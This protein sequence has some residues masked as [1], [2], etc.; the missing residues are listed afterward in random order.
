MGQD[1]QVRDGRDYVADGRKYAE[2]VVSGQIPA[3]QWVRLACQRHLD[4]LKRKDWKYHF[5][6]PSAQ[7]VCQF[8]E[9]M[10]HVEGRWK[11]P[12]I[13]LEDWQCF[14][15]TS[16]FGWLDEHKYRRFRKAL[17]VI[18]R[19]NAKSTIAAA[20][21]LYMLAV[22]GEPGSK[23]FSAATTRDQAKV[24]WDVARKM[25]QRSPSFRQRCGIEPLAHSIAIESQGAYFKPLSRDS[26]TLE[27]LN[28]HCAIIDELHAHKTREVFDVLDEATGA[29]TQPLVFIIST[30]GDNATGVFAEQVSYAQTTLNSA[31]G[32]RDESYFSLIYTIDPEDDWTQPDAWQKANPNLGVSVFEQDM[33]IRCMQAQKNA[34]SQSSFLTKRLNVRVGAG[35]AYFNMLAWRD[36]CQDESLRIEDFYGQSCYIGL[37]LA[38]RLDLAAKVYIFPRGPYDYVFA[39][40]YLPEDALQRGNPN[41]DL[42][43]GWAQHDHLTLIDGSTIDYEFIER[44]LLEDQRNFKVLEV[45]YD[46]HQADYLATRLTSAGLMMTE[47]P[48]SVFGMS[49]P[50]KEVGA[51]IVAGKLRHNGNPIL[52]WNIGNVVAKVDAKENVY[53]RKARNENKIDCAVALII[54]MNR[55]LSATQQ[56]D[57]IYNDPATC[58]L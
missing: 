26:D 53:P 55:K 3:C 11:T 27:G 22:D 6:K 1:S 30:E 56:Q 38:S 12:N 48:Q 13:T 44:D 15:L 28:P 34:E 16:I 46:K 17:I 43:R 21:G 57:S 10:P 51:R 49:E 7:R 45:G 36:L 33:Q 2:R 40:C 32:D 39:K 14:M 23:V 41:Y 5:S 50:M 52:T 31:Y 54:G 9:Q 8:V 42:Y 4:D 18:P 35:D 37:D 47:V 25:V 58:A 29:R 20:V 19:K 24:S